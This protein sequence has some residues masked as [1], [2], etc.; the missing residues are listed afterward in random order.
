MLY[1]ILIAWILILL[2]NQSF[3]QQYQTQ[4]LK[5]RLLE[6]EIIVNDTSLNEQQYYTDNYSKHI[7]HLNL[8]N[9]GLSYLPLD[10]IQYN[11][12]FNIGFGSYK[13]YIKNPYYYISP[14]KQKP[15]TEIKYIQGSRANGLVFLDLIHTQYIKKKYPVALIL[16]RLGSTGNYLH[17]NSDWYKTQFMGSYFNK[18]SSYII[19]YLLHLSKGSVEHN[20]G[21]KDTTS[22]Y[23]T[24][25]SIRNLMEV[26]LNSAISKLN[27]KKI[28]IIQSWQ[29]FP[30]KVKI[31][32]T[33]TKEINRIEYSLHT[34]YELNKYNYL[35]DSIDSKLFT[36]NYLNSFS[37]D[38]VQTGILTNK[39]VVSTIQS[40]FTK[41][42][43][44]DALLYFKDDLIKIKDTGIFTTNNLSLGGI[45]SYNIYKK[46]T[47]RIEA[48][49][50]LNGYS[51]NNYAL[52]LNIPFIKI[53]PTKK[54]QLYLN[55][56]YEL[57]SMNPDYITSRL[58]T[59]HYSWE[60]NFQATQVNNISFELSQQM[61]GSKQKYFKH[62][63]LLQSSQVLNYTY[64]DTISTPQQFS[65]KININSIK[66]HINFSSKHW[67]SQTYLIFQ[68]T[69]NS[70][71]VR[72]PKYSI[73]SSIYYQ[74]IYFNSPMK[75]QMGLNIFWFSQIRGY[76]YNPVIGVFYYDDNHH[77]G[78][79]PLID[80]FINTELK[81]VNFYI[82]IEHL[83]RGLPLDNKYIYLPDRFQSAIGYP[84]QPRAFRFG[85]KWRLGA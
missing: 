13:Q 15:S 85:F 6:N 64:Y 79:Y 82:K 81:Q 68:S 80:F 37:N 27:Y 24:D 54:R 4:V 50:Y 60:N 43:K 69:S 31:N 52:E 8:G 49:Y 21:I 30:K 66:Y 3:A 12:D 35:D 65:T 71:I 39:F 42:R 45:F 7:S 61:N 53:N 74:G 36:N 25:F 38:S 67:G 70:Y 46:I 22:F 32:D 29:M 78:N 84:M 63:I 16:N 51:K 56:K 11:K 73:K 20:G 34:N 83:F 75:Y 9:I 40:E 18:D 58:H 44:W 59:N 28:G 10:Q 57:S 19:N 55:G 5:H 76:Q 2:C 17:Q 47:P 48:L 1:K 14:N 26:R 23:Q 77:T 33:L 41:N 62:Q 72:I